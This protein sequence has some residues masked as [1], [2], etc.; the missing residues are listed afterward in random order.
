MFCFFGFRESLPNA[1]EKAGAL[2]PSHTFR[3]KC[4]GHADQCGHHAGTGGGRFGA[5]RT[6]LAEHRGWRVFSSGCDTCA[7]QGHAELLVGSP[8]RGVRLTPA[9][10]AKTQTGILRNGDRSH[11]GFVGILKISRS[12]FFFYNFVKSRSWPL[13]EVVVFMMASLFGSIPLSSGAS[14]RPNFS[15]IV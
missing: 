2:F 9:Q 1:I 15:S 5:Q 7:D 13:I 3:Q 14:W 11:H 4:C 6:V 12:F 8:L 10:K